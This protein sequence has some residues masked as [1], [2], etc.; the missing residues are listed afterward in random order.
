MSYANGPKIVTDGLV[1]CLDAGNSKRYPGSG[2]A[3]NDLSGNGYNG[4]IYN[5]PL[6][7]NGV[8]TLSSNNDYV[9]IPQVIQPETIDFWF[10]SPSSANSAIIYA[11]SNEYNS[12]SWQWSLFYFSNVLYWRPNS[13]GAGKN[14]TS[15][16]SLNNWHHFVMTRGASRKVYVNGT[17]VSSTGESAAT[18]TGNIR[19]GNAGANYWNGSFS[20]LKMYNKS[21]SVQ[22]IQQN[23]NALKGRFGL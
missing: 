6:I 16:I 17:E 18:V 20:C 14:I 2:T 23:Y 11:G 8:I 13:A 7:S 3:W 5:S 9:E 21:L 19:I 10:N 12:S 1:L 15:F 22:E 4:T